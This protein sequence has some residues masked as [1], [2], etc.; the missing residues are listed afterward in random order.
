MP[1]LAVFMPHSRPFSA[2][3]LCSQAT[4]Q[5]GCK[6]LVRH[7]S[8]APGKGSHIYSLSFCPCV[9]GVLE[10]S[11]PPQHGGVFYCRKAVTT[12]PSITPKQ[13]RFCQEYIVDY[14]GAQAAVRAGY[15]ANSARKTASRLLTNADIL[16]R[17]RELQREQTA[18]LAL[19]QDY[20]LQQ[21]VDTYRCCREPEPVLVYDPDAGGMVE[22][23]K[24]Q[25][26]SKGALHALELIGKHLGMYQDKLKL[27]AKLDTGQLGKVL[28]QL[29]APDG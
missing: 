8:P 15:A 29:G 2:G 9:P 13:E 19:T 17:V 3:A 28:E 27:D 24:Y 4:A 1:R 12:V 6:A 10:H 14:N 7:H 16:A 22:S 26:D 20:V 21:L 23:G 11:T 5:Q 25:F 18:R